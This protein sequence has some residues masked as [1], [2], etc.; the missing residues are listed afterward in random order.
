MRAVLV[1]W[2]QAE[3]HASDLGQQVRISRGGL[4]EL[5]EHVSALL[6]GTARYLAGPA[7]PA[8]LYDAGVGA[9]RPCWES[10][11]RLRGRFDNRAFIRGNNMTIA[12]EGGCI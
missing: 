6:T 8:A 11:R 2:A 4:A 1:V 3:H 7:T 9:W 10:A 5:I 12:T